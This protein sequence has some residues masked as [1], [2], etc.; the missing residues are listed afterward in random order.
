[1]VTY[2]KLKIQD[3]QKFW[4]MMDALDRETKFMLY[5]PGERNPDTGRLQAAI[6]AAAEGEDF[7]LAAECDGEI[8]GYI[9]A[10]RGRQKRIAHT[11]YIVVGVRQKFRGQGIGSEFFRRLDEW[12]FK[13]G[14]TRLELTVVCT[15]EPAKHLYERNGFVIE[16]IRKKS[17]LVDGRFE[18]EYFMAKILES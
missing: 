9:S 17:M 3:T 6:E 7:L 10:Q 12:A 5:E 14:L 4:H 8:V 13:K 2:R 18:D 15:N 1:M 16:G 11:A